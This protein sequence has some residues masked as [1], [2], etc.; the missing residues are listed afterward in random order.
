MQ[1]FGNLGSIYLYKKEKTGYAAI[2]TG[3]NI[4][5]GNGGN[6]RPKDNI[7]RAE[8]AVMLYNYMTK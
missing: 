4:I 2:L 6:L 8:A 5:C 3:M 1:L 7:T